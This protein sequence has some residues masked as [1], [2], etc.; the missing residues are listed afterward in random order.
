M[1]RVNPIDWKV[2][3]HQDLMAAKLA[4]NPWKNSILL[5]ILL[6]LC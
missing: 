5:R 3:V 6:M 1:W 4:W 2:Q